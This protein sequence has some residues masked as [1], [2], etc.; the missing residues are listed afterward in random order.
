[1]S[2]QRKIIDRLRSWDWDFIIHFGLNHVG[3]LKGKGSQYNWL[4]G[5]MIEDV[6]SIQDHTLDFVGQNHK[7]FQWHRFGVSLECKSLCNNTMYDKKG[8]LKETYK[9]KLCSLRSKRKLKPNEVCDII[10]V[11]MKDGAFIVPKKAA[12][13]SLVYR[14]KQVDIEIESKYIIEISGAKNLS[15]TVEKLDSDERVKKFK[16][17]WVLE[18]KKDF[19]RKRK[20][21]V[22]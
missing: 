18:A 17:L 4:R 5:D 9:L 1:M 22:L 7:D 12:L 13:M 20:T 3:T 2:I 15:K 21:G 19:D 11:V 8:A 16:R 10:L 6:V 14:D